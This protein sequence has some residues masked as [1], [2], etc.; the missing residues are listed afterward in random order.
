MVH[1]P[2]PIAFFG[3]WRP[4]GGRGGGWTVESDAPMVSPLDY[5]GLLAGKQIGGW[6]A[7]VAHDSN[8]PISHGTCGCQAHRRACQLLP[9]GIGGVGHCA[10]GVDDW[11]AV[12][13]AF[14][15]DG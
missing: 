13:G 12:G 7:A 2:P 3:F 5:G 15:P 9:Q 11:A 8:W 4:C 14:Q 10:A 6:L 1:S